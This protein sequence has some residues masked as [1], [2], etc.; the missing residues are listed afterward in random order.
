MGLKGAQLNVWF[1]LRMFCFKLYNVDYV[2]FEVQISGH[3][4]NCGRGK[5]CT[6]VEVHQAY[7]CAY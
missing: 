6:L 4:L 1:A 2:K 3:G 7:D 5:E